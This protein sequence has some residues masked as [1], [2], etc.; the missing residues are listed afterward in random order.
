M[1]LLLLLLL[2]GDEST[3]AALPIH[4]E[5]QVH[6]LCLCILGI[7]KMEWLF[8]SR[9]KAK[10]LLY[11]N[12]LLQ[13]FNC[14]LRVLQG[15]LVAPGTA[16]MLY[17]DWGVLGKKDGSGADSRKREGSGVDSRLVRLNDFLFTAN[18]DNLNIFKASGFQHACRDDGT[19]VT[20]ADP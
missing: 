19:F 11:I 4:G 8:R 18:M 16:D 12:Q 9:L 3:F 7:L 15:E 10:N 20:T 14:F 17:L 5:I 13:V 6:P 1:L 2:L